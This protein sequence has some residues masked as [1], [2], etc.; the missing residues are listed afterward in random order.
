[1]RSISE[2]V[3]MFSRIAWNQAGDLNRCAKVM[4]Q[5]LNNDGEIVGSC[6]AMMMRVALCRWRRTVDFNT[7]V[8]ADDASEP[9]FMYYL[10]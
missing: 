2:S 8:K 1:M 3:A 7:S 10:S 9:S 4:S 6:V 5:R